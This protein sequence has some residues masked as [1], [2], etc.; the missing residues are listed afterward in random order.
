MILRSCV[1]VVCFSFVNV[2]AADCKD[3]SCSV[4][5][6]FA[7][8]PIAKGF[9]SQNQASSGKARPA[10]IEVIKDVKYVTN[11]DATTLIKD[12]NFVFIDT[13]P[14]KIFKE[15]A[16]KGSVNYEYTYYGLEGEKKYASG[17]H[18]TKEIVEKLTKDG[19]TL[20][21]FCQ[22]LTCHRGSNAVI[23]A[24]CDWKIPA[25]KIRWYGE[26]VPGMVSYKK[27]LLEGNSCDF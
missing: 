25:N 22:S 2:F 26:G 12:S 9:E 23:T 6:V 8:C 24:V 19:K 20:V 18:L 21:F 7:N 4:K 3:A 15:C 16:I 1:I 27:R 17:P 10:N 14:E 13:R 11:E 5:N